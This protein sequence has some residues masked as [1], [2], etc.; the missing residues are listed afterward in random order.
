MNFIV[1]ILR[2]KIGKIYI[3]QTKDVNKRVLVHNETGT[4]YTSKYRP[5]E[6]VYKEKYSTRSEAMQRKKFLKSGAGRD[7]IKNEILKGD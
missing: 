7:W 5:W 1:Y 6:L 3:G 4:G 2:N